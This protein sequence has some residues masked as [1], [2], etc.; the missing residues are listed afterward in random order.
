[1]FDKTGR[2][3]RPQPIGGFMDILMKVVSDAIGTCL[4][5]LHLFL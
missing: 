2:G 1:L 4:G 3:Q 5:I